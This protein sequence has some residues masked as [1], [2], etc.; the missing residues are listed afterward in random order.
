MMIVIKWLDEDI[1]GIRPDWSEEK[2][3]EVLEDIGAS[4]ADQTIEFGYDIMHLLVRQW[5]VDNNDDE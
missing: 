2:C 3:S 1:A 4:L 5:E